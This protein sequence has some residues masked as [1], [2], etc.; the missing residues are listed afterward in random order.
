MPLI[1]TDDDF[2]GDGFTHFD[3]PAP[4][5]RVALGIC[6]GQQNSF[7]DDCTPVDVCV[8]D[9]NPKDFVGLFD[10]VP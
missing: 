9:M 4:L 10:A 5:G 7:H 1:Y 6:M 2:T 3:L 8:L